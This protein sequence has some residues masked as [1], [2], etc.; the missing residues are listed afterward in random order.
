M[1]R[2]SMIPAA[3][4][5]IAASLATA[6]ITHETTKITD[7]DGS[8][9]AWFGCAAAVAG[10]VVVV[11]A[12]SDDQVASSAGS[13]SIFELATG[14]RLARLVPDEGDR[15]A[16]FGY[17][18]ATDGTVVAVGAPESDIPGDMG[19][20]VDLY[21]AAGGARLARILSP[22]PFN[23]F[24]WDV[25]IDGQ[26]LIIGAPYDWGDAWQTGAAYVYDIANPAAPALLSRLIKPGEQQTDE[27]RRFGRSVAIDGDTVLIAMPLENNPNGIRAGSVYAFTIAN[28][29]EPVLLSR[30]LADDGRTGH[31]FGHDVALDQHTAAIS[32]TLDDTNGY[33]SGAVYVFDLT[34]PTQPVQQR[35]VTPPDPIQNHDFGHAVSIENNR[36]LVGAPG[37]EHYCEP[38]FEHNSGAA[39]LFDAQSGAMRTKYLASDGR[40]FDHLGTA[41]ALGPGV[42][43]VGARWTQ[44]GDEHPGA[45]YVFPID[46]AQPCNDADLAEPF[47]VLDT[48]DIDAFVVA[49]LAREPEADLNEDTIYDLGDIGAFIDAFIAGCP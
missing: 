5:A 49:F 21:P 28:P 46:P 36:L 32:A 1:E 11:G 18:V 30:I 44:I 8:H 24:G 14:Q 7:P 27:G 48:L 26:R 35:K 41:V 4:I 20:Y 6:Q 25:A 19:G 39:F 10:P 40:P 42:A 9:G 47:G 34:F 22:R 12:E 38:P 31:S 23:R 2:A 3:M 17:A 13:A 16:A 15:Y 37:D 33:A 45:A 43:I 29:Q